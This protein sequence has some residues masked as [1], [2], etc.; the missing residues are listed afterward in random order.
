MITFLGRHALSYPC[1]TTICVTI[2]RTVIPWKKLITY[3][4]I[5]N[6]KCFNSGYVIYSTY[7]S[8]VLQYIIKSPYPSLV[9]NFCSEPDEIEAVFQINQIDKFKRVA[10]VFLAVNQAIIVWLYRHLPTISV[11]CCQSSLRWQTKFA[12]WC[13]GGTRN[14]KQ[15]HNR[16]TPEI[17]VLLRLN[18]SVCHNFKNGRTYFSWFLM[19]EAQFRAF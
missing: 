7:F 5:F 11:R 2:L 9:R 12:E 16:D 13:D 15:K 10:T 19:Q 8:F 17:T 6:I 4:S 3:W 1:V 14:H 18:V